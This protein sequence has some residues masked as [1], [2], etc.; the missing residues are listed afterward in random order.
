MTTMGDVVVGL[1]GIA[2]VVVVY[3]TQSLHDA[4]AEVVGLTT[5]GDVVVGL[6]GVAEVVV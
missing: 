2:E 6:T 1:T 3:T 5:T 4:A